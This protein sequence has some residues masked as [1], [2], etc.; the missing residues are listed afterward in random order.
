MRLT[1]PH[2]VAVGHILQGTDLIATLPDRLAQRLA[3]PFDLQAVVHPVKLPEAGI[4]LFW[5][6][7][8]HRDAGHQWL[9]K[10]IVDLFADRPR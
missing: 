6:A 9:R 5:H 10:Q 8:M 2:F 7:R 3:E 4:D 1:V